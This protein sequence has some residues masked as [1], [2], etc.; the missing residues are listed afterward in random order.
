MARCER[1]CAHDPGDLHNSQHDN[2]YDNV[3]SPRRVYLPVMLKYTPKP[4]IPL[5]PVKGSQRRARTR[6]AR[7]RTV[8]L[9]LG[10]PVS[11]S[12]EGRSRENE[13]TSSGTPKRDHAQRLNGDHV[14][15]IAVP[16]STTIGRE[17][18]PDPWGCANPNPEFRLIG[19][20]RFASGGSDEV[21]S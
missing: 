18:E 7:G 9:G 3:L 10:L 14:P 19:P 4:T 15:D 12:S 8:R 20:I 17:T 1:K 21:G 6:E 2:L 16:G 13:E 11:A 5:N